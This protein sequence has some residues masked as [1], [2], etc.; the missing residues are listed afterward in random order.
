MN[1]CVHKDSGKEIHGYF[2]PD[3]FSATPKI[4]VRINGEEE[5]T[6]ITCWIFLQ[7]AIDQGAHETGNVAFILSDDNI[8]GISKAK[9]VELSDP[10]SGLVF[11][12]R[13]Q[14]GQYIPKKVFRLETA[15]V[16]QSEIDLAVRPH[17]QFFEHRVENYGFETVR[18][19]LEI[20]HQPSV[21]VSGRVLL[22]NY[23][24]Y[25]N[26]NIN[27]TLVSLRDPFYELATR[28]I[29]FSRYS[30]HRFKLVTER[31]K[32]LYQ[33]VMEY[34]D[35]LDL[36]DGS[37]VRKVIRRAPKDTLNLLSSPFTQQLVA[38]SPSDLPKL[39]DVSQALD[40]LSQFSL[41]E[42]G[43]DHASYPA[44]I[45]QILGLP[46]E[47]I[48]VRP[49]LEPVHQLADILR[50]INT[51]EHLLEADLVLYHFIQK[52]EQRAS[53]PVKVR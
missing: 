29:V 21:Y 31:D 15:Y 39:D 14:P 41:F 40:A 23:L 10:D 42:T 22:K 25:I 32:S 38:S 35:G 8:P 37:Q 2:V 9:Q 4:H 36:Q 53:A 49:Q 26:Y 45:T 18:Q 51:V 47:S 19:M 7:G 16:P 33:P 20:I 27:L 24:L 12:R 6:E 3:G 48:Q 30:K 46:Q 50:E 34:F 1:F 44:N 43:Q 11:Y 13:A 28:L 17:F 5:F 52:A